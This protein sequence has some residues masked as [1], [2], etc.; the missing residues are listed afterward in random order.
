LTFGLSHVIFPEGTAE[1]M[2]T[3]DNAT[4]FAGTFDAL[5]PEIEAS[6]DTTYHILQGTFSGPRIQ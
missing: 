2:V 6:G 3:K 4:G 5:V 1:I